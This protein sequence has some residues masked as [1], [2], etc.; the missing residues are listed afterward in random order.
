MVRKT[1]VEKKSVAS[2]ANTSFIVPPDRV[3]CVSGTALGGARACFVRR[4]AEYHLV[5]NTAL[6]RAAKATASPSQI[7]RPGTYRMAALASIISRAAAVQ[8]EVIM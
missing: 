7:G 5:K 1:M 2:R 3:Q 8:A 4:C 6:L